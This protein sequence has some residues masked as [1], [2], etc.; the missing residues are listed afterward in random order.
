MRR[1]IGWSRPC[2]NSL[3]ATELDFASGPAAALTPSSYN[4][5]VAVGWRRFAIDGDVSKVANPVVPIDN[6]ESAVVGVSYNLK[7]FSGRVALGTDHEGHIPALRDMKSYSVDLGGS[8][9]LNRSLAVTGG[10]RYKVEQERAAALA[11][12]RRDSQAVYIGTAVK[13]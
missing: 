12:Q 3:N 1:S 13:F 2:E 11:D 7:K 9:S 6:R 8:Y 4:L 5:G 10:V